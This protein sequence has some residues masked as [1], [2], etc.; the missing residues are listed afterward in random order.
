M[1]TA[2]S[3]TMLVLPSDYTFSFLVEP[4]ITLQSCSSSTDGEEEDDSEPQ[5]PFTTS[6]L[7]EC[8]GATKSKETVRGVTIHATTSFVIKKKA[9]TAARR[10]KHTKAVTMRAAH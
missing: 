2:V 4:T 1:S 5:V 3:H 10:R 9:T 6:P 8:R 7:D